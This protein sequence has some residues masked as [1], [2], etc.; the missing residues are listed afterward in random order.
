MLNKVI[1]IGRLTKDP[2]LRSTAQGISTCS[3][4]I[5]VDRNYQS[6]EK[7]TDFINCTAWRGTA[8][9]VSKY[10]QKGSLICAEGSIQ[11]RSCQGDD[12][13]MHYATDVVVDR[14]YFVE[15]KRTEQ[16]NAEEKNV[17][18]YVP[19]VDSLHNDDLPF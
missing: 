3:F 11:T 17:T 18:D 6:G 16:N 1:L 5:A 9:F 10:F 15:R 12:G 7:K 14:V 4:N 19:G 2:E 13:K 8:E